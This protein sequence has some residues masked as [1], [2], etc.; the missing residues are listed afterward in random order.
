MDSKKEL[1]LKSF[2]VVTIGVNSLVLAGVSFDSSKDI[3]IAT[4]SKSD[5]KDGVVVA[6]QCGFG[7][8]CGGGNGQCG[9]GMGCS[10]S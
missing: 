9:F 7:L 2:A 3:Q 1:L 5:L 10:G 8:G 6:G 4:S